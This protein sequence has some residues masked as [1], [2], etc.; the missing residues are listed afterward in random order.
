MEEEETEGA[1]QGGGQGGASGSTPSWAPCWA[2]TP[3]SPC[4]IQ[5]GSCVPSR[6]R[7][8]RTGTGW[9]APS[10]KN[11]P[12]ESTLHHKNS[13]PFVVLVLH[14]LSYFSCCKRH[15]T[16]RRMF[17]IHTWSLKNNNLKIAPKY[18][19]SSS[20]SSSH[21]EM[22]IPAKEVTPGDTDRWAVGQEDGREASLG[23]GDTCGPRGSGTPPT[24]AREPAS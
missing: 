7:W 11:F 10:T 15:H 13:S 21:S 14:I 23:P 3:R 24:M 19:V 6:V 9:D 17:I 5:G 2:S 12:G 22:R 20:G 16:P 18:T 8:H 4:V 1:G